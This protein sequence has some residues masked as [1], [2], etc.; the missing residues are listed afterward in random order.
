[1]K[2]MEFMR[3]LRDCLIFLLIMAGL[4]LSSALMGVGGSWRNP[5][6]WIV[7]VAGGAIFYGLGYMIYES[8]LRKKS[9][10]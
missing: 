2:S 1:M 6:T 3:T 7:T 10:D 5:W 9:S 4:L 8:K